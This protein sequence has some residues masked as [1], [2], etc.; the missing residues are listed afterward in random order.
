VTVREVLIWASSEL[1]SVQIETASL[2]AS[3]LLAY[4]LNTSRTALIAA[5]PDNITKETQAAFQSFINRR[6][7]GE[8]I[9]YITGKK[10]FFALDFLVNPSVLVP[11]PETEILVEASIKESREE[12]CFRVLELCTGSGAVAIAL[13]HEMPHLEVHATDICPAALEV[14]KTNAKRLLPAENN[15]HFHQGDLYDSLITSHFSLFPLLT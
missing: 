10:E 14:A 12:S 7:N 13:K 11:R 15:I 4:C 9:A 1:K 2:D 8:C 5:G 6:L 3:I